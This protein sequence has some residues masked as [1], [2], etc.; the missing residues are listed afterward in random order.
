MVQGSGT[1]WYR[2]QSGTDIELKVTVV[3]SSMG[4]EWVQNNRP[5]NGHTLRS[6][7]HM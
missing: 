1:E 2:V 6:E 3:F 7:L 4:T 5:A